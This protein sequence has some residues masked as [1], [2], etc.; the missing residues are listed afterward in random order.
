MAGMFSNSGV[1]V[2]Q[3]INQTKKLDYSVDQQQQQKPQGLLSSGNIDLTN[4]PVVKNEDG[5]I[6]T[7]RSMSVNIDGKEV[8]VP[9]VSDDGKILSPKESVEQFIKTGKHLGMFDT[10]ENA[11]SYAQS[12]HVDQEK[13]Y[14]GTDK[15]NVSSGSPR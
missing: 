12:L 11:T 4:R 8:L 10:P 7:V 13:M 15:H 1:G 2:S 14:S 3:K 5:T 6:S 9:T